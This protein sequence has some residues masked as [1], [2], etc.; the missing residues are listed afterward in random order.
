MVK[1]YIEAIVSNG[2]KEDMDALSTMLQD[3]LY[4]IKNYDYDKYCD[5]KMELYEM[6][7]GKTLT[8]EMAEKWVESMQPMAKWDYETT[9]AVKKQQGITSVDDIS[10]YVVMNMLYSD[11]NNILGSGDDAESLGKYINATLDWLN[12]EDIGKDKLYNYWKYVAN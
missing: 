6:A 1:K 9:T 12:D 5:Y 2:K 11:M 4:E 8:K 3:V 10:F 7:Y